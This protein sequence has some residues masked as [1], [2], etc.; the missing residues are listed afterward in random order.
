MLPLSRNERFINYAPPPRFMVNQSND[1]QVG[2]ADLNVNELFV[3]V[4]ALENLS[5]S[6]A[7]TL[8]LQRK[9]ILDAGNEELLRIAHQIVGYVN[10]RVVDLEKPAV[11]ELRQATGVEHQT[12][13]LDLILLLAG[14][15]D[16]SPSRIAYKY[17]DLRDRTQAYVKG[18]TVADQEIP[19]LQKYGIRL[20]DID[21]RFGNSYC[22]IYDFDGTTQISAPEVL[23][24]RL[25]KGDLELPK[26][27]A[28]V[29]NHSFGLGVEDVFKGPNDIVNI[30]DSETKSAIDL[31]RSLGMVFTPSWNTSA[32]REIELIGWSGLPFKKGIFPNLSQYN[33]FKQEL[34]QLSKT[35]IE[36]STPHPIS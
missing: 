1:I 19:K 27:L 3:S 13:G 11:R 34:Y 14:N 17:K 16:D 22:G 18:R 29:L 26:S 15:Q 31:L 35:G 7:N 9:S 23:I 30:D 32:P 12:Q 33:I 25:K 4:G 21:K 28:E 24:K 2:N 36:A 5:S 6:D 8:E 10:D 20:V